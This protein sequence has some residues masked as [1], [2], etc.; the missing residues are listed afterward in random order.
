MQTFVTGGGDEKALEAAPLL[1]SLPMPSLTARKQSKSEEMFFHG[2]VIVEF[3]GPV[4]M[5]K[6]ACDCLP[7]GLAQI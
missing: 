5:K 3:S 4:D 1:V 2:N 7:R 6:T